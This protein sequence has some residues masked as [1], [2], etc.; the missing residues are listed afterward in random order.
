MKVMAFWV[1]RIGLGERHQLL[2]VRDQ[3]HDVKPVLVLA[4]LVCCGRIETSHDVAHFGGP[5]LGRSVPHPPQP[6]PIAVER[7]NHPPELEIGDGVTIEGKNNGRDGMCLRGKLVVDAHNELWL[8]CARPAWTRACACS[9]A[10]THPS[11]VACSGVFVC[12]PCSS[13]ACACT[14]A[15]KLCTHRRW[16]HRSPD[17]L[18]RWYHRWCVHNTLAVVRNGIIIVTACLMPTH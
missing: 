6:T 3:A 5:Q 9:A 15:S 12:L 17:P 2:P 4:R 8:A 14:T 1:E 16:Y 7:N 13:S 11:T 10:C 18:V